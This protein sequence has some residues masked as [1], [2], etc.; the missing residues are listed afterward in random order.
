MITVLSLKCHYC[1]K[2]RHATDVQHWPGGVVICHHCYEWHKKALD[3]LA[4]KPPVRECQECKASF[5]D[6]ADGSVDGNI[7]LFVHQKDGIYSVLCR[8]CSD[9]YE[10]KRADLYGDTLYGEQK[11][12]KGSK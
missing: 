4:G 5:V 3:M 9:A 10:T 7:S 6:Q 11:R 1:S 12:L 8:T 2:F